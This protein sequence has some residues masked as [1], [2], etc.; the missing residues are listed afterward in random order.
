MDPVVGADG[1]ECYLPFIGPVSL[2]VSGASFSGKTTFV[3]NLIRNKAKMFVPEPEEIMFVYTTWQPLYDELEREVPNISFINRIPGKEEMDKFTEDTGTHRMVV[4]DDKMTEM[5]SCTNLTEYFTVYTH[6]KNMSTILLL[7]NIFYQGA[8]CM[9]DISLN[10]QGIVLFKN[11][12]SPR[13]IGILATQMFLGQKR[14]WFMDA[15]DKACHRPYGYLLVDL[16]SHYPD[17]FQ[18]R[19]DIFP[20]QHTRVFIQQS[21]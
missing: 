2:I 14:A 1:E 10:V 19:T 7:Q 12:R 17:D 9:R 18:L 3:A 4:I 16:S 13:Q 20:E 15:Y 5:Q 6:H 8:K 21:G 11:K